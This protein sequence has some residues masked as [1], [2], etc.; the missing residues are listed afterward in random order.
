[1]TRPTGLGRLLASRRARRAAACGAIL[2][3]IGIA[4]LSHL[5]EPPDPGPEFPFKDKLA[6]LVLF[7]GLGALVAA[8][9]AAP[10]RRRIAI[11]VVAAAVASLYG[12]L[13]EVHQSYV[14]GRTFEFADMGADVL[15]GWLGAGCLTAVIGRVPEGGA[16]GGFART[17]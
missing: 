4:V 14:Q 11:L 5:P 17:S 7:A 12:V 1:M 13:D 10:G 8:S 15:G 3:A 16:H 2:W 6:H 9:I